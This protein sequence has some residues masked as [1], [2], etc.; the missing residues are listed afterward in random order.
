MPVVSV[1]LDSQ[2]FQRLKAEASRLGI[3]QSEMIRQGLKTVMENKA[4]TSLADRMRDL[5]ND[6]KAPEDLSTNPEY[7]KDYGK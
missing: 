6:V 1:K 3:S 5:I 4:K 2:E 7:L